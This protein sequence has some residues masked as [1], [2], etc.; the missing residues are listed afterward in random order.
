MTNK[1]ML[2]VERELLLALTEPASPKERVSIKRHERMFRLRGLL[3]KQSCGA[4]D[5]CANGCKLDRESPSIEPAA[6]Q[7]GETHGALIDEG[8]TPTPQTQGEPV[9]WYKP[10][11]NGL[12]A[13]FC[14]GRQ[15]VD[16]V[17]PEMWR[18]LYAEQPALVAVV[19]PALEFSFEHWWET[20]GQYCRTDGGDYEK[21]FAYRA[22]EAALTEVTRL[23]TPQ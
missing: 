6:Q 23:N 10:H 5:G 20:S 19:I 2:S 17:F 14:L 11:W 15:L 7:Q 21:T 9:A 4:C 3:N 22:Y 12:S 8:S 16:A 1:L 13:E 18:K